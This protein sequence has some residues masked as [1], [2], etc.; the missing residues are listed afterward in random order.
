MKIT[1]LEEEEGEISVEL[2]DKKEEM[3]VESTPVRIYGKAME[4]NP[5][6]ARD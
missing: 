3:P 4:M 6:S 2:E 1:G 5:N